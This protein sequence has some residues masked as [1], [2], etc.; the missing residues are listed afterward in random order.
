MDNDLFAQYVISRGYIMPGEDMDA[1]ILANDELLSAIAGLWRNSKH[2][3]EAI[4]KA[5]IYPIQM[6][7]VREATPYEVPI[8]RQ[9]M[10]EVAFIGDDFER[11]AREFERRKK[12][13]DLNGIAVE[14]AQRYEDNVRNEDT[15]ESESSV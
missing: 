3:I 14:P 1:T 9:A 2:V 7:L 11:Y 8:L 10:I 13:N 4:I 5:R 6:E 15:G 12:G